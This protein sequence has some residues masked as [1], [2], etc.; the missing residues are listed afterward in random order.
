MPTATARRRSPVFDFGSPVESEP[1]APWSGRIDTDECGRP[2]GLLYAALAQCAGERDLSLNRLADALGVSYWSLSTLRIGFRPI[3]A[4]DDDLVDACAAFLGVPTLTVQMLAGLLD[5]ADALQAP[6]LTGA[7]LL[8]ARQ[9]MAVAPEDLVLLPPPNPER[10]LQGLGVDELLALHQSCAACAP[11]CALLRTELR[12][13]PMSK[14]EQLRALLVERT[15]PEVEPVAPDHA[16]V[17]CAHCQTRLRVPH[18]AA[19]GEIRCPACKTEYGVHWQG[20]VCV[21]QRIEPPAADDP[22]SDE[23]DAPV[24]DDPWSVLGLDADSPWEAVERARRTLLQQYHPDRLGHVSPLVH[25][26]AENA[27]KRVNE[28]YDALRTRRR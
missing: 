2:G 27:F 26:L 24:A 16:V 6:A 10:P 3:E 25:K 15:G 12:H 20:Q 11:V 9:L 7:D 4:L 28:A 8:H 14:T 21:V 17:R 5:P 18:L 19:A 1:P 13:R 23:P 22:A